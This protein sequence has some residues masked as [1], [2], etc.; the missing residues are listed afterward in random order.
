MMDAVML[1]L[2]GDHPIFIGVKA[3]T[4]L[5]QKLEELSPA[6]QQYISAGDSSFLRL[7]R[8]GDDLYVGKLVHETLTTDRVE[9]IRS[10]VLS[11]LRRIGSEVRLP[12]H[13]KIVACSASETGCAPV[14]A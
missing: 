1:Q 11:I 9:D 7:C 5:R 10:N 13:L 4:A 14:S 8:L 12:A 2:L 6:N 3:D